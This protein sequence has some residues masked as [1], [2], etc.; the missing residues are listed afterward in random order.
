MVQSAILHF[1]KSRYDLF[2]Y[3]VMDD[4]VHVLFAP[5]DGF[6]VQSIVHSWKSYTANKLQQDPLRT[7]K[8]WIEEYFDRIIRNEGDLSEKANYIRNNPLKRW[9][10]EE[11]YHWVWVMGE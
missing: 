6:K 10:G 3:V 2:G 7:G 11:K 4:H 5:L 1:N 8:I 9:S